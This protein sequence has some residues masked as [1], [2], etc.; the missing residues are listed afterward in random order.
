MG[1]KGLFQFLK[2][3]RCQG[4]IVDKR[5]AVDIFTLLHA[6]K[7]DIQYVLTKMSEYSKIARQCVAVFD[8]SPSEER[9]NSLM[10]NAVRRNDILVMIEQINMHIKN[11]SDT[12]SITDRDRHFLEKYISELERQ[13]WIPSPEYMWSVHN[14]LTSMNIGCIVAA[15]GVE[16]D[17][18][19]VDLLQQD[20]IDIVISNDSDIV[21]NGGK[22]VMCLNGD[23][24]NLGTILDGLE[25]TEGEWITFCKLCRALKHSDPDFVFT[26]M[27]V[28]E[29]DIELIEQRFSNLFHE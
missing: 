18:I 17:R 14:A 20:Q 24:Y 21:A 19:L 1:I 4:S 6:S 5:V 12:D 7:G 27:K 10:Y 25:F 3:Y 16:A 26:A 8:G 2:R 23:Y 15:R 9:T 22:A 29:G 11:A 28:Y 13:A